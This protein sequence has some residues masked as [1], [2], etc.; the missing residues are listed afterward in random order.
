M[1]TEPLISI[2][3]PV[4]NGADTLEETLRAAQA[5]TWQN[6]E[7]IVVDDGSTD[8]SATIAQMFGASDPR[9]RVI[10][11]PNRGLPGARNVGMAAARGDFIAPLDADDLWHPEKLARQMAVFDQS[12]SNVA[13]I[14]TWAWD[15]DGDGRM[16]PQGWRGGY[17]TGNILGSLVARNLIGNG[18]S[19]LFRT[20]CL[21]RAGGYDESM[22][23]GCEDWE[24]YLRLAELFEIRLVPAVLL[25][26]R[27]RS[28]S[29]ST[30]IG[31]ML[32]AH[33]TILETVR[34]AH[35]ELPKCLF[36]WSRSQLLIYLSR[37]LMRERAHVR[38]VGHLLQAFVIDPVFFLLGIRYWRILPMVRRL[39]PQ[40]DTLL[41]GRPFLPP[42]AELAS[43]RP[44]P[45]S[46]LERRRRA[47]AL[48]VRTS[49]Q[50]RREGH[51]P[52]SYRA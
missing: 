43:F 23:E 20:E 46:R 6:L 14:Y 15:I 51:H 18:S 44:K 37:R 12:P 41:E 40:Q 48:G 42:P 31:P 7:I 50:A 5:Q 49:Q 17:E 1:A 10:R 26:Y 13:L 52:T 2:I 4:F 16:L 34:T 32:R 22:T 47:F 35:P 9:L 30:R 33:A 27:Q 29:L 11:Q 21:R 38:A 24:F 25:G 45:P 28:G 36:R 3:I 19:V 39:E 8:N